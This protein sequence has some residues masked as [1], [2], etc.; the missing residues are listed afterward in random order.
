LV[1]VLAIDPG[2]LAPFGPAKFAL[3]STV[4][5][6]GWAAV[7]LS[8][9]GPGPPLARGPMV[10]WGTFLG[11]AVVAAAR[12]LDPLYAWIGTPERHFG[13]LAWSLCAAAF[14]LGQRVGR[15]DGARDAVCRAG[16]GAVGL[17]GLWVM[18]EAVGWKPMALVA[19]GARPVGTLGSSAYVGA[20]TVL[21]TP[22]ALGWAAS[23]GRR[24]LGWGAAGFG[25]FALVAAGARAAWVGVAVALVVVFVGTAV[26][27]RR[28]LDGRPLRGGRLRRGVVAGAVVGVIVVGVAG[29]TGVVG[30]VGATFEDR[31]GGAR[32]RLDEW[33]VAARV[34]AEH[35]VT[36]TGPE[37]YRIAFGRAVDDRYE[38]IHGRDPLPDRAHSAVLDV[39]ATTGLA[40]LVA[41]GVLLVITGRMVVR[42]TRGKSRREVGMA[43]GLL[44]YVVQSLFLFP[45]AEL[46]PVAW[47]L[48]GTLVGSVA[49]G[50]RAGAGRRSREPR[51]GAAAP[52]SP[53]AAGGGVAAGGLVAVAAAV[54]LVAGIADVMADRAAK[55]TLAQAGRD[56]V[57]D[58]ERAARLRPD[59]VRYRLVAARADEAVGSSAGLDRAIDEV[60]RAGELTMND[61]VV[62]GEH[63]RLLL[64]RAQ[65]TESPSHIA[66]ARADLEQLA[67][68]DPRNAAVLLRLGVARALDADDRGAERAWRRAEA[69][70]P[71]KAAASID[72]ARLY[73][74]QGRTTE[75]RAAAHRAVAREPTN[76]QARQ[77]LAE[78]LDGT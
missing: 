66:Q 13:V 23:G 9:R 72:L 76:A 29:A 32:G 46:D 28:R 57:A 38:Q 24:M 47:L 4:V 34:V 48:A 25:A 54:A 30:R 75:A 77:A 65:R 45:I 33:R 22:V 27:S 12:G 17:L 8:G 18:A 42:A 15:D 78:T 6:V 44:A 2:G 3:V 11:I 10:A 73:L 63:A 61:P 5:L 71:K 36:G 41:Y 58:P 51:S 59:Q 55:A 74:R 60:E 31:N 49:G 69:L 35:P 64:A 67:I 20:A 7:L 62:R 43:A 70:A 50:T 16:A 37:G 26:R 39:A 19:A 53:V 14:V 56:R 21:L 68:D 52:A 1:A 40:G